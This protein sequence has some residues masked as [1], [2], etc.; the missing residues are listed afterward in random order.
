MST[1]LTVTKN[2]KLGYIIAEDG[3]EVPLPTN[4]VEPKTK[5]RVTGPM[6]NNKGG[7]H[8]EVLIIIPSSMSGDTRSVLLAL[9]MG[10]ATGAGK[11][12]AAR[13]FPGFF[14]PRIFGFLAGRVAGVV[15]GVL[16][17]NTL[18]SEKFIRAE[19]GKNNSVRYT[20]IN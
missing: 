10:T 7:K 19:F 13:R 1:Q 18:A 6:K 20:I 2:S 4:I 15:I 14:G 11:A 17:P 8:F 3:T 16:T 5:I 12:T 9:G